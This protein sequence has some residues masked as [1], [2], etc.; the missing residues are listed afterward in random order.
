ML[1]TFLQQF[2]S[3]LVV[4]IDCFIMKHIDFKDFS[5]ADIGIFL[6]EPLPNMGLQ[7]S[8]AAGAFYA[9]LTVIGAGLS[10]TRFFKAPLVTFESN[11]VDRLSPSAF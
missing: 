5:N 6:R 3:M 8:V 11:K 2:K 10:V 7:T 4:D 1:P 9:S